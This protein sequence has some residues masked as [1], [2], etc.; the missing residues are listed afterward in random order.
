MRQSQTMDSA[1]H[2]KERPSPLVMA[3]HRLAVR[4]DA[5][6]A[7]ADKLRAENAALRREVREAAA[8]L[9]TRRRPDL[10]HHRTNRRRIASAGRQGRHVNAPKT[11][12]TPSDVTT[13]VVRAVLVK[14]GEA[15]ASQIAAEIT[16]A[17]LQDGVGDAAPP[18]GGRAVRFLAE[19]AGA[20]VRVGDDGQRRY[21]LG[22]P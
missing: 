20:I 9:D 18:V 17:R 12:A 10:R 5:L 3:A 1:T 15:T 4:I 14:L 21:R 7:E 11:R 22:S 8:V 6:V 16:R 19:H 13:D 2:E